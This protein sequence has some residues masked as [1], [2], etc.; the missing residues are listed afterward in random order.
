MGGSD[1]IVRYNI[2]GLT[3]YLPAGTGEELDSLEITAIGYEHYITN[4]SEIADIKNSTP[5]I[6]RNPTLIIKFT[7]DLSSPV[8]TPFMYRI[9]ATI[10]A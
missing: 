4:Y 3:I 2:A 10:T 8:N 9:K 5:I 7:M 1:N 6:A